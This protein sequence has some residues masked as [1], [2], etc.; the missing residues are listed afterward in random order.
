EATVGPF[1]HST[2]WHNPDVEQMSPYNPEKARSLLT[3]AGW[4]DENGD[5]IREQNGRTFSIT[6][7]TWASRPGM[8]PMAEALQAQ[9]REVGIE[10]KIQIL[11]YGAIYDRVKQGDWDAVLASFSTSDP[12]RYLSGVYGSAGN[13]NVAR[14]ENAVVESLISEAAITADLEKRYGI[15]REIQEIVAQDVPVINIAN[16]K[17]AVGRRDYVQGFRFNPNAHDL[18]TNPEMTVVK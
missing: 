6:I 18:H 3:A 15:Y 10:A 1:M 14:Y 16:Y 11:E 2:P 9:F 17:M 4:V 13:Q 8:P 12:H 7:M 5:G